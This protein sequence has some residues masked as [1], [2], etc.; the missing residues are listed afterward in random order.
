MI[1]LPRSI[2]SPIVAP[3]RGT[4]APVSGSPTCSCA[5]VGIGTP[6]RAIFCARAGERQRG[7]GVLPRAQ[8][9]GAV[10]LGEAVQVRDAKAHRLHR[11]DHR[12]RR[13]GAAGRDVDQRVEATPSPTSGAWTSR[14]STIGAPHRCV[15]RCV[16]DRREDQRGIDAAQAHVRCARRGDRPRVRPAAA[17][18]HRQRPQV[19]AVR[20]RA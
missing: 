17:V 1:V 5:S 19:H 14:L 2:T 16:A 20:A 12:G 3:S 13:R 18:E 15:T 7:P 4:A 6:W 9:R 10:R 11:L 8:R